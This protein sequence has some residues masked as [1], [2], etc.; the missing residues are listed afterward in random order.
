MCRVA[1]EPAIGNGA[2]QTGDQAIAQRAEACHAA[3]AA[4]IGQF[5]RRGQPHNVGHVLSA[6]PAM[7][8]LSTAGLR[9][10]QRGAPAYIQ[11]SYSLGPIEL[12]A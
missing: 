1:R 10:Q 8:L 12:V 11:H 4:L 2:Q 7:I 6:C 3:L 9:W 5:Q